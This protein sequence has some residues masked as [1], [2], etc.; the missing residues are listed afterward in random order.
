MKTAFAC[1]L[2]VVVL[3]GCGTSPVK[4]SDAKPVPPDR[5]FVDAAPSSDN[6]TVVVIRDTGLG[7]SGCGINIFVDDK[8][9]ATLGTGEEASIPV[10][11]GDHILS[12]A[13]TGKGLC[14]LGDA[15]HAGRRDL[16]ISIKP[17]HPTTFRVGFSASGAPVFSQTSL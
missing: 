16:K 14:G 17:Q 4:L 13:T 6:G 5:L 11:A 3:A 12:A 2:A 9:A 7:G 8:K 10:V 15:E 1:F